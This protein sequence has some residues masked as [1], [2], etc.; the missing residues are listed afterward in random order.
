MKPYAYLDLPL[1]YG[2]FCPFRFRYW[3]ALFRLRYLE[4]AATK[5]EKKDK[6][7]Q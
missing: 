6:A 1:R 4:M 5:K 2:P 3:E 7:T